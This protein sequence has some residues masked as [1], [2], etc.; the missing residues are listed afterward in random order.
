MILL[1]KINIDK[2]YNF[3]SAQWFLTGVQ[4]NPRG[5]LSQFQGFSDATTHTWFMIRDETPSWPSVA[6]GN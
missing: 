1:I 5:S 4:T 6:A 3:P 2:L